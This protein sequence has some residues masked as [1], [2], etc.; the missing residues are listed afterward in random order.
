[1][2]VITPA[3]YSYIKHVAEDE[4]EM[5]TQLCYAPFNRSS[6]IIGSQFSDVR[7]LWDVIRVFCLVVEGHVLSHNGTD[8]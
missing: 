2:V 4:D 1:M 5:L 7:M 8:L 6:I 3:F